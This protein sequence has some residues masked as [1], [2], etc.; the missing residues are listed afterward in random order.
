MHLFFRAAGDVRANM[1][2]ILLA[3]HSLFLREHNRLAHEISTSNPFWDDEKIYQ[4]ARKWN[5]AF[6]QSICYY[7][8]LPIIG[9]QLP[10]YTGYKNS[11]NPGI[12]NFFATVADRFAHSEVNDI[13]A[14][15]DDT[16][17][18][19]ADDYINLMRA[20]FY[21]TYAL[22]AGIEPLLRGASFYRET[23]VS[24]HFASSLQNYLFGTP[25]HGGSDLLAID[26]QRTR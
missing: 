24:P 25:M 9:L 11:V 20:Y 2:P 6:M 26:I 10:T 5:V 18:N 4:T 8:Y 19:I 16:G 12:D 17:S 14:R 22:S 3:L 21:P 23:E 13:I 1:D 15:V 7:E